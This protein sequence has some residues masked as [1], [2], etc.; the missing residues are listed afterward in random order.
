MLHTNMDKCTIIK[1][2]TIMNYILAKDQPVHKHAFKT[3]CARIL[4]LIAEFG[5]R[6]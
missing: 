3:R 5:L 6:F 4:S 1:L 2:L